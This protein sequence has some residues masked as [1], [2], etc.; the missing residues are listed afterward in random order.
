MTALHLIRQLKCFYCSQHKKTVQEI[1]QHRF[2]CT[3]VELHK[4]HCS[5]Q[6]YT[7]L[8]KQKP[9]CPLSLHIYSQVVAVNAFV[10]LC[11]VSY[12]ELHSLSV[13][14]LIIMPSSTVL[15]IKMNR[16]LLKIN[17]S[18]SAIL[19]NIR[20]ILTLGVRCVLLQSYLI[21][22]PSMYNFHLTYR[23]IY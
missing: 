16:C 4:C 8:S 23:H 12:Y 21:T 6:T 3:C 7:R 11:S 20:A 18:Y 1:Q 9:K 2:N 17:M 14:F 19:L 15:S 22:P 5:I 13:Y 10:S